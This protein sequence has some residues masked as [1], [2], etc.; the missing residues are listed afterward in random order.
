MTAQN[1]IKSRIKR[2]IKKDRL[3]AGGPEGLGRIDDGLTQWTEPVAVEFLNSS[4][5]PEAIAACIRG[6]R[7]DHLLGLAPVII[8]FGI[9]FWRFKFSNFANI[10][11]THAMHPLCHS[12]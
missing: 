9:A 12:K 11:S 6:V 7:D 1:T 5:E 2:T 10:K 3:L 8:E 4:F